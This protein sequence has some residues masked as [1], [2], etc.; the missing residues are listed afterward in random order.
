MMP[1]TKEA[2]RV[3]IIFAVV[4]VVFVAVL[5]WMYHQRPGSLTFYYGSS[6]PHCHNVL[7]WMSL[8]NAT[9]ATGMRI[10]EVWDNKDNAAVFTGVVRKCGMDTGVVPV[11]V[12]EDGVCY[13]G[14]VEITDYLSQ[15]LGITNTTGGI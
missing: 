5:G 7:N 8:H 4:M 6:C 1:I 11:L 10:L 14:E 12:A 3:I 13:V 15:R 2:K 9:N